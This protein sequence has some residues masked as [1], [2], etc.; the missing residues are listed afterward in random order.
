MGCF[1]CRAIYEPA[2]IVEWIDDDDTGV[3]QTALCPRCGI[4]AVIAIREGID[5]EFLGAMHGR[6]F[7]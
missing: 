1:Y 5:T 7:S 3:G 2:E 4:D 6:W